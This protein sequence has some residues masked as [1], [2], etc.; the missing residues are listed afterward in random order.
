MGAAKRA[1]ALGISVGAAFL[2]LTRTRRAAR[3]PRNT[4][5]D[6]PAKTLSIV[7]PVYNERDLVLT[8]L[9]RVEQAP[10]LGLAKEIIIVDDGS[11]DGT[12]DVLA[13]VAERYHVVLHE[14]NKGKGAAL[15]TGFARAT[16]DIVLVQDADLEYDPNEYPRLLEPFLEKDADA[17]FGSRFVG[18]QMHKVLYFWHSIGNRMLTLL[19]NMFTDL[20]L[21]DMEVCYKAFRREIVQSL[22]LEEER[23]GFEPEVTAKLSRIPD[24]QLYEVGISYHGR[25]YEQGK[26]IVAKDALRALWCILKY[27]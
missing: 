5:G 17:V 13:T 22:D 23:F 8:V 20:N 27:R 6:E 25:T 12:R 15:H 14:R 10:A 26:K 7:M 9:E 16:G 24:L 2:A 18:G 21:T 3:K 19:S 1:A 11:T 4:R